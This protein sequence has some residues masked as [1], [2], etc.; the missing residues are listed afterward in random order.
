MTIT[1][2][3][4]SLT[5]ER[6]TAKYT[7]GCAR[8]SHDDIARLAYYYYVTHGRRD[9]QDVDDWLVAENALTG[10]SR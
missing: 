2:L 9:G 1:D 5:G 10:H 6:M 7:G 4:T 3:V 8:P